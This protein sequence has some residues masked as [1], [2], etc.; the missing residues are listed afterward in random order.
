MMK[1]VREVKL[2][3]VAGVH[4]LLQVLVLQNRSTLIVMHD[5]DPTSSF[6]FQRIKKI[7]TEQR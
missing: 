5:A 7:L 2:S 3:F 1:S 4:V 6:Y